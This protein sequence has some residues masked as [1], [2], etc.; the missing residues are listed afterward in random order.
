MFIEHFTLTVYNHLVGFGSKKTAISCFTSLAKCFVISDKP[1]PTSKLLRQ[2]ISSCY[3]SKIFLEVVWVCLAEYYCSWK[4]LNKT[5]D[6]RVGQDKI[7]PWQQSN[8]V[9]TV[10]WWPNPFL[11]SLEQEPATFSSLPFLGVAPC[12]SCSWWNM[13]G[14]NMLL[15]GLARR[16]ILTW[17]S[18]LALPAE[19]KSL[20]WYITRSPTFG[21]RTPLHS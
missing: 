17:S 10:R 20:P 18:G 3:N 9:K 14:N 11:L 1:P 4:T 12:L 2:K 16:N 21:I 8:T 7:N 5:C 13:S 15:P 6:T 19:W